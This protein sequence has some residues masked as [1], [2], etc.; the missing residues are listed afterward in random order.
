[1]PILFL[2]VTY[3]TLCSVCA[4][5]ATLV[6]LGVLLCWVTLPTAAQ[7]LEVYWER[8]GQ[9]VCFSDVLEAMRDAKTNLRFMD[10]TVKFDPIRDKAVMDK[11]W[12]EGGE[13]WHVH[14]HM[15]FNDC[16]FDHDYWFVVR[17]LHFDS[18][19]SFFNCTNVKLKAQSCSFGMAL[20][21]YGCEVKFMDFDT[22][23]FGNGFK[24]GY[25]DVQDRLTFQGCYF[26]LNP[27]RLVNSE[28]GFGMEAR[29]VQIQNRIGLLDLT[30]DGCT[31]TLPD[32][33]QNRPDYFIQLG[34]TTYY[35]LRMNNCRVNAAVDLS[36]SSIENL[37]MCYRS[38]FTQ[39]VVVDAL[40]LN[41]LNTK[42][43][44]SSWMGG[45][46]AVIDPKTNNL[47]NQANITVCNDEFLY[48]NLI[49]CYANLYNS[50]RVQG[51]R[52][53]A[54]GCYVEWKDIETRYYWHRYT[55]SGRRSDLFLYWMNLFLKE[56]CDYGTNPL[57]S[58]YLSLQVLLVFA[59]VYFF[60]PQTVIGG[61]SA[62]FYSTLAFLTRLAG[63][64]LLT[65]QAEA[66][67][68][69]L[70]QEEATARQAYLSYIEQPSAGPV[71]FFFHALGRLMFR[72]NEGLKRF[73]SFIYRQ[74]QR[75]APPAQAPTGWQKARWQ[76]ALSCIMTA[77]L[78]FFVLKRA[79]DSIS[80]SLNVF[81]T[82]G[83]GNVPVEGI[84]RYLTILEGFVG[85]FLLSIFS[86]SLISQV[87]Q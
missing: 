71:P 7:P 4:R 20:R 48:N 37:F 82:L 83:F 76:V 75:I 10:L 52:L 84:P 36:Q 14:H 23:R 69:P 1:V 34:K 35:N 85:W 17:N 51:N 42:L 39:A 65:I 58:I 26:T 25:T 72:S 54:N 66:S 38:Q 41:E 33:L 29:L 61:R 11:R 43:Q 68:K 79:L 50:F 9:T 45:K 77:A 53:S 78:A 19:L 49:G 12:L 55:V 16:D 24:L 5:L 27:E 47:Y 67:T 80:L 40:Q 6:L 46:L 56:F 21:V 31:F 87:I 74:L 18:Y 2:L 44:W 60:Y 86:V 57:K 30:F 62:N 64:P 70:N 63:N 28:D 22:C 15:A 32:W 73:F 3:S 13:A 81:S 8:N 59:G